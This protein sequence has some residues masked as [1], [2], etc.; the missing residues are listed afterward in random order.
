MYV[1]AAGHQDGVEPGLDGLA[2]HGLQRVDVDR[3]LD[4]HH[5]EDA[6]GGAGHRAQHLVGGDV[7]AGGLHALDLAGL[8]VDAEHF[9]LLVDLDAA[10]VGAAAVAPG[11][12][13]VAGH[14]ARRVVQGAED[15][16]WPAQD[17]SIIGAASFT[18]SGP[19]TSEATP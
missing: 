8:H 7:A 11:H 10:L 14:R 2:D 5:L 3:R 16:A 9:G 18:T 15:G 4:V 17:R 19:T 6:R 1:Q 12:R 13:V